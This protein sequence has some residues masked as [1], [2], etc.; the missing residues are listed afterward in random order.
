MWDLADTTAALHTLKGHLKF[1]IV[2]DWP[3]A[4]SIWTM[5]PAPTTGRGHALTL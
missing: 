4:C 2:D 3:R 1:G 5:L